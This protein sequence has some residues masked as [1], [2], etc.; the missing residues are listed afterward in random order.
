[1]KQ[2]IG[3]SIVI[4]L[5]VSCGVPYQQPVVVQSPPVANVQ[6]VQQVDDG[7]SPYQVYNNGSGGQV[8]YYTDPYS[9]SSYYLDYAI[10]MSMLN[11]GGY[12]GVHN[13]YLGHRSYV[14]GYYTNY[15]SR[16]HN[17]RPYYDSRSD[18]GAR[19]YRPRVPSGGN[20][21]IRPNVPSGRPATTYTTRTVTP[22]V[23][24][25]V[26]SGRPASVAPATRS[27]VPNSSSS[28]YRPQSSS[29]SSVPS[30]SSGS[31]RH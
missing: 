19:F 5:L 11:S 16:Y 2:F 3:F 26:P 31:R 27:S 8:V 10:F 29:R 30:G 17:A 12:L 4:I 23:R 21:Y 6:Q 24:Q 9:H 14:D 15:Y 28:S 18:R 20:S 22:T 1:M 13:Y 25:N 7:Y